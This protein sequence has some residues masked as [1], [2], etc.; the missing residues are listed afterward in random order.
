LPYMAFCTFSVT[1]MNV[2]TAGWPG[3]KH[4]CDAR[5]GCLSG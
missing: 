4:G 2:T 3:R 5:P 1:I